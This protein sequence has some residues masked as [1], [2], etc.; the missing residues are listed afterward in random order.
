[1]NII[2]S[3]KNAPDEFAIK[4]EPEEIELTDEKERL[5]AEL[6]FELVSENE[7]ISDTSHGFNDSHLLTGNSQNIETN[8]TQVLPGS[9]FQV[10]KYKSL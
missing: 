5:Q 3:F 9:F 7:S 2:N 10:S 4:S 8:A 1:M 6:G